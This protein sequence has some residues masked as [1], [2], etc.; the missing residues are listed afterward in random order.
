MTLKSLI[1]LPTMLSLVTGEAA[2]EP[3]KHLKRHPHL[4]P[5]AVLSPRPPSPARSEPHMIEARPGLWISTWEHII[6]EGNGRWM[7]ETREP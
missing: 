6:D 1:V 3:V 4:G 5:A 7:V 2:A